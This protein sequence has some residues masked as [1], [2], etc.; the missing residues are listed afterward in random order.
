VIAACHLQDETITW[1]HGARE[2]VDVK[3]SSDEQQREAVSETVE[4]AAHAAEEVVAPV[5]FPRIAAPVLLVAVGYKPMT[6]LMVQVSDDLCNRLETFSP[7]QTAN[8][9]VVIV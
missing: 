8:G 6:L 4:V 9:R 1:N 7:R 5:P 2:V 3:K